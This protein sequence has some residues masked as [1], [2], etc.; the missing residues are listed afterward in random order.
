MSDLIG[1]GLSSY[2]S[3]KACVLRL[4]KILSS[5]KILLWLTIGFLC[6][7]RSNKRRNL[8]TAML[9]RAEGLDK[10]CFDK[11]YHTE[12]FFS[13]YARSSS[14]NIVLSSSRIE[15]VMIIL[16]LVFNLKRM[17]FKKIVRKQKLNNIVVVVT[18]QSFILKTTYKRL[19]SRFQI[20]NTESN[21]CRHLS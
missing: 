3:W 4:C 1:W 20:F 15:S 16:L 5:V 21:V 17:P 9:T 11:I 18:N 10:G 13:G 14:L 12:R 19:P 2:F 6:H 7:V 8:R